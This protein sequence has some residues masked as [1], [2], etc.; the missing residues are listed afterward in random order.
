MLKEALK[1]TTAGLG[2]KAFR[3]VYR[4]PMYR[5]RF[6]DYLDS[7]TCFLFHRLG[8]LNGDKALFVINDI[9]AV[10]GLFYSWC[11]A[12]RGLMVAER[13]GFTPVVDWQKGP[14]FDQNG[15]NGSMNPFEYFFEPVSPVSLEEAMQSQNV[16]FFGNHSDGEPFAL[17]AY[18]SDELIDRFAAINAKYIHIRQELYDRLYKETRKIL[19]GG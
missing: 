4:S 14:Y 17:Y 13:Y 6:Q 1:K 12:C 7:H 18:R 2:F 15:H 3:M 19:G 5:Q 11:Q 9:D 10:A 16:A 8:E